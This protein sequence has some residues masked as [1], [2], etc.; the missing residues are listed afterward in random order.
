MNEKWLFNHMP[1][2]LFND[3]TIEEVNMV[4]NQLKNL[5]WSEYFHVIS[6]SQKA[7]VLS[8]FDKHCDQTALQHFSNLE[9][10]NYRTYNSKIHYHNN[11][12]LRITIIDLKICK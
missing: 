3:L 6:N 2:S 8:L 10:R 1:K 5:S 7:I 11:T 12:P 4:A 9:F